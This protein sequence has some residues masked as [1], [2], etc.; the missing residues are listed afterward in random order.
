MKNKSI[1]LWALLGFFFFFVLPI[2]I[3]EKL[4]DDEGMGIISVLLGFVMAFAWIAFINNKYINNKSA[5]T[6]NKTPL[7]ERAVLERAVKDD[8]YLA[9][10]L[11]DLAEREKYPE[12]IRDI[13]WDELRKTAEEKRTEIY[14]SDNRFNEEKE[15]IDIAVELFSNRDNLAD[16][17]S[18]VV[19]A[20]LKLMG[21]DEEIV[22]S[23][24]K[25]LYDEST[26]VYNILHP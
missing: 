21:Y 7:N 20:A 14:S 15:L 12:N 25:M 3:I 19:K 10:T 23:L 8:P 11:V 4:T 22:P 9:F 26:R 6:K 18:Y 16:T 1:P 24:Y 5:E 13:T 2:F 17:P